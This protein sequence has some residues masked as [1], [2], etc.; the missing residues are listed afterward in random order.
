MARGLIGTTAANT[1]NACLRPGSYQPLGGGAAISNTQTDADIAFMNQAIRDDQL[2]D[3]GPAGVVSPYPTGM[4]GWSRQGQ[5]YIP[6]RGWLKVL[7]GDVIAIDT[8]GW[9]ILI[10][11][12][13]A[14]TGASWTN[15]AT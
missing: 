9:P 3:L 1:R 15:T 6:N 14:G 13:S 10:S 12:K 8:V 11:A 4:Q 5:L 7:P 2:A